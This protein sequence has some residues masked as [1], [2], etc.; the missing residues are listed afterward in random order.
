MVVAK[1]LTDEVSP[2]FVVS[3]AISVILATH[4]YI[5]LP[6]TIVVYNYNFLSR[7]R[8]SAFLPGEMSPT[9]FKFAMRA[10]VV[11]H[12]STACSSERPMTLMR[13]YRLAR[14]VPQLPQMVSVPSFTTLVPVG[15]TT[16]VQPPYYNRLPGSGSDTVS[17]IVATSLT[18]RTVSSVFKVIGET[19]CKSAITSTVGTFKPKYLG[20]LGNSRV[21]QKFAR[22]LLRWLNVITLKACVE[23]HLFSLGVVRNAPSI[24]ASSHSLSCPSETVTLCLW[25]SLMTR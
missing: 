7:H 14:L 9:S 17:L 4:S 21:R 19:W 22:L 1:R 18:S 15:S 20:K 6:L 5:T 25:S 12:T 3:E 2:E 24:Y 8:K 11:A 23:W 13:F 16:A 10:G